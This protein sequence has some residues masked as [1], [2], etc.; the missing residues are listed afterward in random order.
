MSARCSVIGGGADEWHVSPPPF[1]ECLEFIE[2]NAMLFT[3]GGGAELI[4][5]TTS[6]STG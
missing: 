1:T 5:G 6:L 4:D 2:K 3:N